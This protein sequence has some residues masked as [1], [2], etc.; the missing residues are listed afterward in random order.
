M[1]KMKMTRSGLARAVGADRSTL[2][3]LL[4]P[5]SA[6]MPNAQIVAE[7][8]GALGVS[9]D[10]LLGLSELPLQA[11]D[12]LAHSLTMTEAERTLVDEQIFT[13]HREAE[14]YKIRHV[15]ATLPDMLKIRAMLRWEYE[16]QLG[17]TPDQ[18]ITATTERVDWLR[19]ANADYEIALPL[20]EIRSF[21]RAEGYYR[22][23]S[24]K[25]RLDQIDWMLTLHDQL[26]P[27]LRIFLFDARRVY[28]S[29]LSIF[30]PLLAVVYLGRHYIAFRDRDRVISF[31]QHFDWLIREAEVS[32]RRLPDILQKLRAEIVPEK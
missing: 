17:R 29:P 2:S 12:L 31:T 30:G 8:A 14:G 10:W 18:A 23:L 13:W 1:D 26:Y 11:G 6:R 20:H 9:S 4:A 21:A 25:V 16:S 24:S 19:G 22:G 27:S 7:C 28:S 5:N 3:Q 32:A 15:P